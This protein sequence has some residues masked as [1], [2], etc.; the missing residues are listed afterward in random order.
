MLN[1]R[2]IFL[3]FSYFCLCFFFSSRRRH[4]RYISVTGVQTCAL[5]ILTEAQG[6]NINQET[7]KESY[8]SRY[9]W[10]DDKNLKH[11]F[12]TGSYY[13]MKDGVGQ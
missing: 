10:V 2:N 5:P 1:P 12:S 6:K 3:S 9:P 4:T 7:W 13:A 8:L 11:L